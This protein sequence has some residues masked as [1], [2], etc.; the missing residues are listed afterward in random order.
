MAETAIL[1]WIPKWQ[2]VENHGKNSIFDFFLG[3]AWG[4]HV[5]LASENDRK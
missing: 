4:V 1:T 2:N 5:V 3:L